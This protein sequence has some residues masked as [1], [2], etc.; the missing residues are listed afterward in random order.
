MIDGMDI[1]A[2]SAKVTLLPLKSSLTGYDTHVA[3]AIHRRFRTRKM[4]IPYGTDDCI[5]SVWGVDLFEI[6][7]A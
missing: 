6:L 1:L 3:R 2:G 4:R 5:Q 7:I